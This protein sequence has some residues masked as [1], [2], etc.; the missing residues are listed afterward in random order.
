MKYAYKLAM[1][2]FIAFGLFTACDSNDGPTESRPMAKNP[3]TAKKVS[4]DRFSMQA[5]TLFVRDA[6]NSLPGPNEPINMDEGPF[7]TKG[8]GPNGQPV[9]YYNFD[10][11]P[12]TPA[13]IFV[14]FKSGA[15]MPVDGQLNIIDD[16]PGE[17]D[18]NDFWHVHKVT[19]PDDYVA[20]SITS[21]EGVMSSGYPVEA[22]NLIVNCPVVPEGST[23]NKKFGGGAS[24]LIRGW[25]KDMVVFYFSF[26]EKTLTTDPNNPMVPVSPIYVTFNINPDQPGGGPASGFVMEM[27]S[28][29][30]HNVVAT[31][32]TDM[33]Y[34]PLW[35][36]NVYNN[37][38]FN[39][40]SNLSSAASANILASGVALVN[41]PIVSVN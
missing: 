28:L 32:P 15:D 9:E 39:N 21:Y 38:D 24:Q 25:Y 26:E 20:N 1:I 37:S 23:A 8:L 31:I 16:I 41:C 29:Q 3:D 2:F 10:V 14:L 34:S 17:S 5:G 27:N 11:L 30:T 4:V 12:T 22:T 19:V 13:P 33:S 7:I 18:Y 40:V 6:N 36:V 35:F